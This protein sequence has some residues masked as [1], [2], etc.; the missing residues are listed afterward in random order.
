LHDSDNQA[1]LSTSLLL[2][3]ASHKKLSLNLTRDVG[4]VTAVQGYISHLDPAVRRCGLL[5]AEI[6]AG[7]EGK[8]LKFDD[9]EGDGQGREWARKARALMTG[10]DER[11]ARKAQLATEVPSVPVA[12]S[13]SLGYR[14]SQ[15]GDSDDSLSG[16]GSNDSDNE[17]DGYTKEELDEMERDLTVRNGNKKKIAIPVYLSQLLEMIQSNP[18]GKDEQAVDKIEMG[19]KHAEEL[20]RRKARF[21]TELSGCNT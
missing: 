7:L 12:L 10:R 2:I 18:D 19:L 13:T 20:I 16:Y 4:F 8:E 15:E 5:L 3:L 9:W 14:N 21:G 6:C 11:V 17:D 1:D